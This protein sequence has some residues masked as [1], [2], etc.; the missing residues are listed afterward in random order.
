[1]YHLLVTFPSFWKNLVC[2]ISLIL[3]EVGIPNLVCG[4]RDF[5]VFSGAV[6][7]HC[8]NGNKVTFLPILK[9]KSKLKKMLLFFKIFYSPNNNILTRY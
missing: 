7:G 9:T 3:F 8:P 2:S 5:F 6:F 4:C 1:M